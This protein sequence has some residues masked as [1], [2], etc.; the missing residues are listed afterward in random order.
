MT[1]LQ[2]MAAELFLGCLVSIIIKQIAVFRAS[3]AGNT[4]VLRTKDYSSRHLQESSIAP[5]D[6]LGLPL[7]TVIVHYDGEEVISEQFFNLLGGSTEARYQNGQYAGYGYS[8]VT[9][10]QAIYTA[11]VVLPIPMGLFLLAIPSL[12]IHINGLLLLCSGIAWWILTIFLPFV[13]HPLTSML[14]HTQNID[15]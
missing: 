2:Y 6:F 1:I 14:F 13:L 8:V 4:Q 12:D 7:Q 3:Y 10:F 11:T 15:T 9:Y 5:F